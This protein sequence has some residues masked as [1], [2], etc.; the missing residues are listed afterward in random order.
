MKKLTA[1]AA[2]A[3][4]LGACSNE[5]QTPT[6]ADFATI[7]TEIQNSVSQGVG[8]TIVAIGTSG[9]YAIAIPAT[10]VVKEIAAKKKTAKFLS[11]ENVDQYVLADKCLLNIIPQNVMEQLG[12]PE[13][14]CNFRL[15]CGTA[16]DVA[17][18][19]FYA[20]ELCSE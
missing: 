6:P 13:N 20:V 15:F 17:N 14:K 19:E 12:T 18:N 10:D 16:D 3:L 11:V 4:A 1:F 8:A 7:E 5:N 2:V 9:D